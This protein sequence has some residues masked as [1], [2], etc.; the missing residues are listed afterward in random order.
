MI[1][2]IN[3]YYINT[4]TKTPAKITDPN[5]TATPVIVSNFINTKTCVAAYNKKQEFNGGFIEINKMSCE[6]YQK[7]ISID[8]K[9]KIQENNLL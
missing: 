1:S 8:S 6:N 7:K 3:K 2:R 4:I 9:S 5:E